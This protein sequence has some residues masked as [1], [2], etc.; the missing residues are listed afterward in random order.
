MAKLSKLMVISMVAL[1]AIAGTSVAAEAGPK[2]GNRIAERELVRGNSEARG[3]VVVNTRRGQLTKTG[4]VAV[5]QEARTSLRSRSVTG[6]SGN[7][8]SSSLFRQ[9]TENGYNATASYTDFQGRTAT[10]SAGIDADDGV[11][12]QTRNATFRNGASANLTSTTSQTENGIQNQRVFSTSNGRG[13]AVTSSAEKTADGAVFGKN[14]V[15]SAGETLGTKTTTV[16][17]TGDAATKT[18]VFTNRNGE[19]KTVTKVI[20]K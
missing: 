8:A 19:A 7:T 1:T 9:R 6:A 4:S 5:D 16:T 10:R 15:N 17:N 3:R 13:G 11:L 14:I 18:T 2:R 20:E 12:L